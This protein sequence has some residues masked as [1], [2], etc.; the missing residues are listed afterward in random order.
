MRRSLRWERRQTGCK[1]SDG[2]P[3][4]SRQPLCP[5]DD[6]TVCY[7][8]KVSCLSSWTHH[9]SLA[10]IAAWV[11]HTKVFHQAPDD[12]S[13]LVSSLKPSPDGEQRSETGADRGT[14]GPLSRELALLAGCRRQ[15][16]L[17]PPLP[18]PP[19]RPPSGP[20]PGV[21]G[22][23]CRACGRVGTV[24]SCITPG[25]HRVRRDCLCCW[26]RLG[27]PSDPS[28]HVEYFLLRTTW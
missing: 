13:G 15:P 11:G 23:L 10:T 3:R 1:G 5:P 17:A 22:R 19:H 16:A 8:G 2:K 26:G 12:G 20:S 21:V 9:D 24:Q 4:P 18:L 27:F 6:V 28:R 25:R 14:A 7:S